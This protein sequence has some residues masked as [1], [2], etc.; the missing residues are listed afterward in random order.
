M[1]AI[2]ESHY[3]QYKTLLQQYSTIILVL[4]SK[5]SYGNDSSVTAEFFGKCTKEFFGKYAQ[6]N[7][8]HKAF[9]NE[10][11]N[12]KQNVSCLFKTEMTQVNK[13]KGE[14]LRDLN[15]LQVIPEQISGIFPTYQI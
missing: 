8:V 4:E 13:E 6:N 10:L 9:L 11:F 2:W 5:I 7:I 15:I 1:N 12:C 14:T 3:N